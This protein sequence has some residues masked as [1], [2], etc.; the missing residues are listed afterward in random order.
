MRPPDEP[1]RL[2]DLLDAL[3]GRLRRVD[4]RDVDEARRRW[5]AAADP[6]LVEHCWVEMI[7]DGALVVAVPSGA[8][9]RRVSDD[10]ATILRGYEGM[11]AGAPG[12]VRTVVRDPRHHP[13]NSPSDTPSEGPKEQGM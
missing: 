8:F 6:V 9:A 13:S 3:A 12:R 7:K 11:G 4:L 10:A 2:A 1:R 5:A